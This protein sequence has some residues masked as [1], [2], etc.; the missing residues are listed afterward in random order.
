[1][2]VKA[3]GA[4]KREGRFESRRVTKELILE[5]GFPTRPDLKLKGKHQGE[6]C[7]AERGRISGLAPDTN[8]ELLP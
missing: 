1:M 2:P 7:A 6:L 8:G 5:G 3:P 4:T